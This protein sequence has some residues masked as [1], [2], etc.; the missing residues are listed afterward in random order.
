M[1]VSPEPMDV[2]SGTVE[3]DRDNGG[4]ICGQE[5]VHISRW[6]C[7]CVHTL[8]QVPKDHYTRLALKFQ[9]SRSSIHSELLESFELRRA[10]PKMVTKPT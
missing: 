5:P 2:S 10:L 1:A 6:M 7:R 4:M 8:L 3:K 9:G